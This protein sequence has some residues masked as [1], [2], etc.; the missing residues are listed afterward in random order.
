MHSQNTAK[1]TDIYPPTH[2]LTH[3]FSDIFSKLTQDLI[4]DNELPNQSFG[5]IT[6]NQ[7][8]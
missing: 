3:L 5:V 7:Q 1:M 6:C 8:T 2:T 4:K